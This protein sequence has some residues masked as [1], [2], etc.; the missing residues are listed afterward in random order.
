M[1]KELRESSG[2]FIKV[3]PI[4][5]LPPCA[6]SNDRVV[7]VSGMP[8]QVENG[9]TA[10]AAK[11]RSYPPRDPP[12]GPPSSLLRLLQTGA[13]GCDERLYPQVM[14][15]LDIDSTILVLF[16]AGFA[17]SPPNTQRPRPNPSP[18]GVQRAM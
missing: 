7:Q 11:A 10:V 5:E 13:S 15:P 16:I 3:L 18:M 14:R 6:L 4:D 17:C 12:G 9:L 2:A 8:P 1:I